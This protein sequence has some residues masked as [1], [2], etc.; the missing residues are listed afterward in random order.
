MS[1]DK[2]EEKKGTDVIKKPASAVAEPRKPI[3]GFEDADTSDYIVPRLKLCQALTK[4]VTDEIAKAGTFLNSVSKKDYGKTIQ[5]V[6]ILM[7]KN[8][9]EFSDDRTIIRMSRN[10]KQWQDGAPVDRANDKALNFGPN[11]E[12]P[13]ATEYRQFPCIVIGDENAHV[14]AF[15]SFGSM[16]AK[17]GKEFFNFMVSKE[18]EMWNFMYTFETKKTEG[19]KGVYYLPVLQIEKTKAT[20]DALKKKAEAFYDL[21]KTTE[22]KFDMENTEGDAPAPPSEPA[23]PEQAGGKF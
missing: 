15:I 16:A 1:K 20:P 17:V 3:R 22:H 4:E 9:I 14:P 7:Q 5:I 10:G 23:A 2:P 8:I 11:G 6:P 21:L 12:P 18:T 19:D 13:A